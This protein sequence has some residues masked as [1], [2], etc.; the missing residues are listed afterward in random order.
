MHLVE[1]DTMDSEPKRL[2]VPRVYNLI[3]DPKESYSMAEQVSWVLP[4]MFKK[5][6]E[7]QSTFQ[8]EP[9][10]PIGTPEPYVPSP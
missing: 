5:I 4:V 10:I 1:L 8:Q 3:T 2:N 9:P 7:F 6:V